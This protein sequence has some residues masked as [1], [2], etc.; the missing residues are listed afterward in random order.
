LA[1]KGYGQVEAGDA[2]FTHGS[3][4]SATVRRVSFYPI[5]AKSEAPH[6]HTLALGGQIWDER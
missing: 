2:R 5:S 6:L 3:G 4:L 1:N